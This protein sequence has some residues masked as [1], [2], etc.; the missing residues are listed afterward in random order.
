MWV[1]IVVYYGPCSKLLSEFSAFFF[2]FHPKR[3]PPLF[4]SN[5]ETVDEEPP[6][7][8]CHHWNPIYQFIHSLV[9]LFFF[10]FSFPFSINSLHLFGLTSLPFNVLLIRIHKNFRDIYFLISVTYLVHPNAINLY[11]WLIATQVAELKSLA[12]NPMISW[13]DNHCNII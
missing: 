2:F 9:E 1:K 8:L 7:G 3:P 12:H 6:C 11:L 5:L 4:Q 13:N 10:W